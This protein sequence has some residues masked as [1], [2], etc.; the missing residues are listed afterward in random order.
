VVSK[1]SGCSTFIKKY[2]L[3]KVVDLED[4]NWKE[5]AKKFLEVDINKLKIDNNYLKEI[6]EEKYAEKILKLVESI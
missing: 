1:S 6:S 3:G 5:G 4:T 2:S